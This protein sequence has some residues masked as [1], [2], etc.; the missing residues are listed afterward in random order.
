M[1]YNNPG[2]E[3]DLYNDGPAQKQA[4]SPQ[5]EQDEHK[6]DETAL[7][8]KSILMGKTFNPGDEVVLEVVRLLDDQVE[9]KYASEKGGEEEEAPEGG[10]KEPAPTGGGDSEMSSMMY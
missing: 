10:G 4:E 6:D 3:E 1:P 9:V 2:S 8:P 5:E 7:L